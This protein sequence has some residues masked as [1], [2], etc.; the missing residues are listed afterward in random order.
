MPEI[1]TSADANRQFSKLL[2]RVRE[3]RTVTITAHGQ[4]VARM[5]PVAP[6]A[7]LRL[8]ARTQLMTR[9]SGAPV[10]SIGVWA[11]D[12][13]YDDTSTPRQRRGEASR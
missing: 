1:V 2:R 8:A 6:G 7:T 9:L 11:R 13:L 3:G 4:P 5:T 10:R 12:E